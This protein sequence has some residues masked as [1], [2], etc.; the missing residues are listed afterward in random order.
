ML[1]VSC[2]P[3]QRRD[4][5]GCQGFPHTARPFLRIT[6][7]GDSP[8][9]HPQVP[10]VPPAAWAPA[11]GYLH[12]LQILEGGELPR[13][14]SELVSIQVAARE[15]KSTSGWL[16]SRRSLP[17]PC[18]SPVTTI[19]FRLQVASPA[20]PSSCTHGPR[21]PEGTPGLAG[22]LVCQC[23]STPGFAGMSLGTLS[24]QPTCASTASAAFTHPMG[25]W[26]AVTLPRHV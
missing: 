18:L 24:Q 20:S 22:E 3:E 12:K 11:P 1:P 19:N 6:H 10:A 16:R 4:T 14:L 21:G 25:A 2:V 23:K 8:C 7:H 13:D 15:N 5:E 26:E 9:P 17:L